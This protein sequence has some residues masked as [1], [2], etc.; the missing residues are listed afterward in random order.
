MKDLTDKQ[1]LSDLEDFC[2]KY[3]INVET[4]GNHLGYPK[5]VERLRHGQPVK[6]I[7]I[8]RIYVDLELLKLKI[9]IKNCGTIDEAA[10]ICNEFLKQQD[11]NIA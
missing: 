4:I 9:D 1:L 3:K 8:E 5:L 10:R 7:T 2:K 11:E 6:R